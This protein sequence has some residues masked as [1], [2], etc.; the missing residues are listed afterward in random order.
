M[1]KG[2]ALLTVTTIFLSFTVAASPLRARRE[3]SEASNDNNGNGN[4]NNPSVEVRIATQHDAT[5]RANAIRDSL[6]Q[7]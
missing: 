6:S 4:G 5:Q 2:L 7:R 3:V 1:K